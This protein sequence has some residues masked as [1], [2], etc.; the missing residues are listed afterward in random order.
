[1]GQNDRASD[2]MSFVRFVSVGARRKVGACGDQ[3]VASDSSQMGSPVGA[4]SL[5]EER[6]DSAG[7][8]A[9]NRGGTPPLDFE[10]DRAD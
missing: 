9:G 4:I 3:P 6:S 5:A 8:G 2:G 10:R 7:G 1:M